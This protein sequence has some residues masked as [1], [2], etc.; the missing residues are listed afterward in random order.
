[1][2]HVFEIFKEFKALAKKQCGRPIKCLIF[3]NGGE[4][5]SRKF[6][7]YLDQLGISWKRFAPHIPQQNGVV[8]CNNRTLVEWLDV[9]YRQRT[10]QP[11][12]GLKQSNV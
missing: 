7:D 2:S 5:V 10:C 6:G 9:S 4:Y 3:D 1:M 8:K 12:F 11:F